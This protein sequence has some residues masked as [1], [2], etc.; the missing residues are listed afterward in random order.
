MTATTDPWEAK[1]DREFERL[2][3]MTDAEIRAEIIAEGGDPYEYV[4]KGQE[5]VRK[6]LAAIESKRNDP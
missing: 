6:A 4:A 2:M 5:C 1:L 3:K